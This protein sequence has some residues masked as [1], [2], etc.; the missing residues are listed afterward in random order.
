MP[1]QTKQPKGG[2]NMTTSV[3]RKGKYATYGQRH[4]LAVNGNKFSQSKEHRGCGPL[5]KY[6]R[7][8]A[9][10]AEY[11]ADYNKNV[12]QGIYKALPFDPISVR[13][14]AET[15]RTL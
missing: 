5:A 11:Y 7:R 13:Q 10:T 12:S 1:T 15:R 6:N 14:L 3:L 2:K 8:R 4:K 9:Q